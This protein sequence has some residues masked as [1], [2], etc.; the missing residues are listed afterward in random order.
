[1]F[2]NAAYIVFPFYWYGLTFR[3]AVWVIFLGLA[4]IS[5]VMRLWVRLGMQGRRFDWDDGFIVL[6]YV[7]SLTD[8]ILTYLG[9]GYWRRSL[10]YVA[11]ACS[12]G[13]FRKPLYYGW[14]YPIAKSWNFKISLLIWQ[15]IW[16]QYFIFTFACWAVKF[17]LLAFYTRLFYLYTISVSLKL[18]CSAMKKTLVLTGVFLILSLAIVLM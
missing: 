2:S 5:L 8:V 1:M 18:T 10:S 4:L 13:N 16:I 15:L 7:P 12:K 6:A 14:S 17:S 3:K 11:C 9:T